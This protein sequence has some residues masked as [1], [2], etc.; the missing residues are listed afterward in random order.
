M[1]YSD[2][3]WLLFTDGDWRWVTVT[4]SDGVWL[5]VTDSDWWWLTVTD[6]DIQCLKVTDCAWWC[7]DAVTQWRSDSDNDIMTKSPE[8]CYIFEN[9]MTERYQIWWWINDASQWWCIEGG[10]ALQVVMHYRWWCTAGGDA[11]K[12]VIHWRLWFTDDSL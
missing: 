3:R 9:N 7:S 11:L 2:W 1:S 10:D 12:V 6:S 4:Y 8:K 5:T